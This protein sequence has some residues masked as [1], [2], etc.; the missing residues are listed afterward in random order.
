MQQ[1]KRVESGKPDEQK[2]NIFFILI[3]NFKAEIWTG[4]IIVYKPPVD[5]FK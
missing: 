1:R 3:N 5:T 2:K 4:S